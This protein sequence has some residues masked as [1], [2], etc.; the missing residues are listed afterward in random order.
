MKSITVRGVGKV[1]VEH[2]NAFE[3]RKLLML[4]F[5]VTQLYL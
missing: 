4:P 3:K 1:S 5:L 2:H